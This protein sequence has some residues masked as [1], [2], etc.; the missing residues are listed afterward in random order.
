MTHDGGI[1]NTALVVPC[2]N[3][4]SRWNSEYWGSLFKH[5]G[6]QWLL[7]DDGST[8]DT[9]QIL[10]RHRKENVSV[11]RLERNAGK[12]E[13]VRQ[14]IQQMLQ[15]QFDWVG[16]VDAD[17]AFTT[18]EIQRYI[19]LADAQNFRTRA[20]WSSRVRM[21]GR[22]I[23]RSP[24]RHA[25][26][27]TIA[28]TLSLRYRDLPYDSQ[29]GLKLFRTGEPFTTVIQRPFKT[30]WL[31]DVELYAR[32][33]SVYG[34]ASGWLWEEPLDSWQHVAESKISLRE[35]GRIPIEILTLLRMKNSGLEDS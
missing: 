18:Q 10:V 5:P 35:M 34:A 6:I 17:G 25:L 21:R 14:G 22:R 23:E 7:V 32:L 31:F 33:E 3:E 1:V 19:R 16:F 20:V 15:G 12:G 4:G 13:A 8:D 24:S 29:A 2:F 27:R 11:R 26:G 9:H 28:T 30:R